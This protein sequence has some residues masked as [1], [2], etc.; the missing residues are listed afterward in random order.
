VANAVL[1]DATAHHDPAQLASAT[2]MVLLSV[3][4]VTIAML[5]AVVALPGGRD[6]SQVAD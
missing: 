3:G 2:H 1:G 5:L 4:I 6:M